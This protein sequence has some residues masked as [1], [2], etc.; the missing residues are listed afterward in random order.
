MADASI[1][2]P[3]RN[4]SKVQLASVPATYPA[5]GI[6]TTRP[7]SGIVVD[8]VTATGSG[9][10]SLLR[11]IP[12]SSINNGTSVGMRIIGWAQYPNSAGTDTHYVPMVIGDYTLTYTSGTVPSA[13]VDG[14]TIYTF[15]GLV[16]VAGT[17]PSNAYSPASVLATNTE[18][19][20]VL[21]DPIGTQLITIQFKSSTTPTMG[22]FAAT[23]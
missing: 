19:C 4:L 21:L 1:I 20:A 10:P 18:A 14:A 8:H 2:T 9:S 3:Q 5:I 12:Y 22:V 6:V 13:T 15:S 7:T 17:P 23:L 11:L 16:Q